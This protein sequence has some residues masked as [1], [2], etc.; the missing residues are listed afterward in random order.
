MLRIWHFKTLTMINNA[1]K[2]I[3][4]N[5][6]DFDIE[7]I[8]LDDK[9]T[10]ELLS[11]GKSIGVFQLEN[12]FMCEVLKKLKPDSIDDII[13][14]VSLN[15]P[16]P[17]ANIP[18]Y[19]ARKHGKE[20]I[21][22]P[23][24]LLQKALSETFGVTIYQEQVMEIAKLIAGYTLAEAD[25]LR[26]AMGKKIRSEMAQ[27]N[28][29]FVNGAVQN[30][31]D[32]DKA[33]E[34]FDMVEKFAGYGFNKSHAAAYAYISYQTAFLKANFPLEF[35]VALLNLEINNTD[36]LAPLVQEAKNCEIKIL[37]PDV[38]SSFANFKIEENKI[39]YALS[40]LK[41]V[42]GAQAELL[43]KEDAFE[44][45]EDFASRTDFKIVNKRA[46]EGLIKSGAL[47]KL[48]PNRAALFGSVENI[49]ASS[50]KNTKQMML[51]DIKEEKIIK[52]KIKNWNFFEKTQKEFESIG[53]FLQNH[54]VNVYKN[55]I[56]LP[57]DKMTGVITQVRIRSRAERKFAVLQLATT[58]D[59]HTVICYESQI[60][61]AKQE[62][63]AVGQQVIL[64][65]LKSDNGIV[66]K[67][68]YSL[69]N[70]ILKN[71]QGKML[72]V[73]NN[74]DQVLLLKN[75]LKSDGKFEITAAIKLKNSNKYKQVLLGQN[76][77]FDIEE[78]V[79]IDG[80]KIAKSH[81]VF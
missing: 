23:H 19:I 18:T 41:N 73:V 54:P 27:Q 52:D 14:L 56:K 55:A 37:P 62:L 66:C 15:R 2:L 34:I 17:M 45:L 26:R 59:M 11:L 60:I 33:Q 74:Q 8:E 47:D 21:E 28:Q 80:I 1:C 46:L 16:G 69:K 72:V 6:P 22:Y 29:K 77:S 42:G 68:I 58:E 67:N 32:K 76:F 64:D 71:M 30:N 51:F 13:A 48:E 43:E 53:L 44:S 4:I 70:F 5:H 24:P 79:L 50:S 49:M 10:F 7:K 12:A 9:K 25:I 63:F 35:F 20:K 81:N 57:T 61:E 40:A 3:K 36:K 31:I 75:V 78:L 65:V 38:N 39:R